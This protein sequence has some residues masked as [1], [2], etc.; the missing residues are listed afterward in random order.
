MKYLVTLCAAI[1]I[2]TGLVLIFKPSM[3]TQLLFAAD[4]SDPGNALGRL[5]GFGLVALAIACWPTRSDSAPSAS[6]VW[7][8]LAFSFLCAIYLAYWGAS[9]GEPGPLLWWAAVGH[10]ILGLL[11]LWYWLA[12]RWQSATLR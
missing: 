5:A 9:T 11:L 4:M 12:S 7:A 6:A 10:A 1:E 3:F 2:P 8:L